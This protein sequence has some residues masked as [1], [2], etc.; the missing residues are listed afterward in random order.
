[1]ASQKPARLTA[2]T[3]SLAG[4]VVLAGV[5]G[6][7]HALMLPILPDAKNQPYVGVVTAVTAD[8]ITIRSQESTVTTYSLSPGGEVLG[9]VTKVIPP[10]PPKVFRVSAVL[11]DGGY[12][13]DAFAGFSYRHKDVL[14]GDIVSIKYSRV[15]GRE[16]CEAILIRRRPGGNVPPSPGGHP[17]AFLPPHVIANAYQDLEERGIPLPPDL[18]RRMTLPSLP[19][20]PELPALP[21]IP[22]AKQ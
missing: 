1:M 9:S 20:A 5:A 3:V 21:P 4:V 10:Q 11:T 15:R 6:P 8:S 22:P 12:P 19:P 18:V 7:V 2:V 17:G 13:R 14:V 16:T